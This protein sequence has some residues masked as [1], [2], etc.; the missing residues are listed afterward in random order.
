MEAARAWLELCSLDAQEVE[1]LKVDDVEAAA[2]IHQYL[3]E[4]SVDDDGADDEWIDAGGDDL[5]GVVVAVEGDVGARL[6]EILQH[7]HPFLKDFPSFP[8]ALLRGELRQG[9]TIDHVAVM[10]GG[11]PFVVLASTLVVTLVLPLVVLL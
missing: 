4:S 10:D 7:R 9:P 1:S 2:A 11:E 3:R 5:V 6:A 8:L